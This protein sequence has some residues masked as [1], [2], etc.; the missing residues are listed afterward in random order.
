MIDSVTE[1]SLFARHIVTVDRLRS[2][3]YN[4]A[5]WKRST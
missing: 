1:C 2:E 4:D 3:R 5:G